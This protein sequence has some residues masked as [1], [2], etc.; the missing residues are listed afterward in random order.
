MRYRA[1]MRLR[2]LLLVLAAC[3]K[4]A[5][6]DDPPPAPLDVTRLYPQLVPA[7]ELPT[8]PVRR[9]PANLDGL[10]MTLAE[11]GSGGQA[12]LLRLEDLGGLRPEVAFEAALVNLERAAR[13]GEIPVH[14]ELGA[15]GKPVDIVWGHDWRAAAC[16]LLPGV[17]Q[18]AHQQLGPTIY[19]VVPNRDALILFADPAVAPKA[20]AAEKA[21]PNK[22]SDQTYRLP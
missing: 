19:A 8:G 21:A 9:P 5:P 16:V 20:L 15:D 6:H 3:G 2:L 13:A 12:K 11:Q 1:A 18:Q 7:N 14:A 17:A 10:V 4:H 22:L